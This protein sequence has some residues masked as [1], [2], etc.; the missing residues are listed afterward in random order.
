MKRIRAWGLVLAVPGLIIVQAACLT[1]KP[2][3]GVEDR[4]IRAA[5]RTA[6]ISYATSK[7][8]YLARGDGSKPKRVVGARSIG[9]KSAAF[10]P[11][12]SP[13]SRHLLFLSLVDVNRGE[14][15]GRDLTLNVLEL[16]G[17]RVA[18]WRR[19][20][21]EKLLDAGPDGRQE[22]S[23]IA[24]AQWSPGGG[25]IALGV[26]R[27]EAGAGDA[28]MIFDAE[29]H[30]L[31]VYD[32]GDWPLPRVGGI[33]WSLDAKSLLVGL[34]AGEDPA[35]GIIARLRLDVRDYFGITPRDVIGVGRD[36]ALSPDGK[37]IA[38]V[39]HHD[40]QWDIV[41]LDEEGRELDRFDKPAG[42]ALN[43]P[44]WAPGGRFLYYYS[45]A[46]T[47]PLGLIQ[48]TM[49]RCFDTQSRRVFD[50]VRIQ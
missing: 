37:K 6:R 38:V 14:S 42:R 49:L 3:L 13:N 50:L 41:M 34:E 19:I 2:R 28:M 22:V 17:A 30:P 27:R 9:H 5:L 24:A 32:L 44:F 29:G 45:L 35:R 36:P 21:L 48:V 18:R 8:V 26:N 46:S 40:G 11:S 23:T 12:L 25:K 16:D 10:M 15:T 47:G 7:G 43:R 33:S 39:D 1:H 20:R 31:H 4:D